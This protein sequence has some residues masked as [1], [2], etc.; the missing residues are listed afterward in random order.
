MNFQGGSIKMHNNKICHLPKFFKRAGL[1]SCFVSLFIAVMGLLGYIPGMHLLSSVSSSY[2]PMAPSTALSFIFLS[3]IMILYIYRPVVNFV[4]FGSM[5]VVV[6]V[7]VFGF[8]KCVE[9]FAGIE[10][11]FEQVPFRTLL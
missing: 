4:R 1:T 3:V 9:Y 6:T 5:L 2:V 10:A 11:S 7:S 8:L